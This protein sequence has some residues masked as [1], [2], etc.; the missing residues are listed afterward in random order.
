MTRMEQKQLS[1][2]YNRG[3]CPNLNCPLHKQTWAKVNVPVDATIAQLINALSAFPQLETIESCQ[4]NGQNAVWACFFYGKYWVHPWRD[5]AG[6]VLGYLGPGL[7]R[8][9]GDDAHLTIRLTTS[10]IAQ[11]HLTV[12]PRAVG[13]TV[14]ALKRLRRIF[15]NQLRP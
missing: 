13:K 12:H 10:G 3:W 6:F 8:E 2:Q 4:G 9:V 1:S 5:L 14:K 11:G 15:G 7:T